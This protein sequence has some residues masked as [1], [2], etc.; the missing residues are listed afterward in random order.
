M[1]R[2]TVSLHAGDRLDRLAEQAQQQTASDSPATPDKVTA[3]G[4]GDVLMVLM[5]NTSP[6]GKA[7][8]VG[9]PRSLSLSSLKMLRI[10][11]RGEQCSG[12][13]CVPTIW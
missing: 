2:L 3:H 8:A 11:G 10:F 12:T 4:F 9:A 6:S 1:Q 5:S 13:A 7:N